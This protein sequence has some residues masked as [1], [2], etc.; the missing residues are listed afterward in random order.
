MAEPRTETRA[1]RTVEP[2]GLRFRPED[3]FFFRP[4]EKFA[5]ETD[6]T[7]ARGPTSVTFTVRVTPDEFEA[8]LAR[9][10]PLPTEPEVAA[11]VEGQG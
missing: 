11:S 9:P 4:S 7:L 5:G 8:F 6:V 3:V 1:W 10:I 2:N